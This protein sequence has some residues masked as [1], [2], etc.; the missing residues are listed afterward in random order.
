M[1]DSRKTAPVDVVCTGGL[2]IDAS[3]DE[4]WPHMIDYTTWQDFPEARTVAGEPGTEGEVVLLQ[5][6]FE[7]TL[8]PPYYARTIKRE[9]GKR[10]IWK[11]FPDDSAESDFFGAVGFSGTVEFSLAPAGEGKTRF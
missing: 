10:I 5:K 9:P 1:N 3:V 2:L 8:T 11:C 7:G 4:V 6:N